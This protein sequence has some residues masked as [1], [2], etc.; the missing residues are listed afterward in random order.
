[1]PFLACVKVDLPV[2]CVYSLVSVHDRVD[3][4]VA[5]G[6]KRN[7]AKLFA[8]AQLKLDACMG[9]PYNMHDSSLLCH[10]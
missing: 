5:T 9:I 6:G 10:V 8:H 2:N 4:R 3:A 1:M 7:L